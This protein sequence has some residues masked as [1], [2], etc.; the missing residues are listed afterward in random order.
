MKRA[1]ALTL[2]ALAGASLWADGG[3]GLGVQ[4]AF[5]LGK[6]S[7]IVPRLEYLHATD[8]KTVAASPSNLDLN[9]T[10]NIFSL[11]VD[12]NYFITGKTGKGLYVLGGLGIANGNLR[13]TGSGPGVSAAT[14]SNQT[15][16]YPE[17]GVGYEFT[18]H[19]G[20]E[21]IYKALNFGDVN[22]TVGSVPVTYSY[23]S[24]LQIGLTVRF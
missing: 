23:T 3:F 24:V 1:A 18:R 5:D 6:G 7:A 21:A 22:L 14:T 4:T 8:S 12:Y 10:D 20:L 2:S 9:A 19:L 16:L 17:V 15:R 13:V 11:G